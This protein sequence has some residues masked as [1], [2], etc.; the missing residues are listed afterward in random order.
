LIHDICVV[1]W[2]DN[3]T[4]IK[5]KLILMTKIISNIDSLDMANRVKTNLG[6]K[7]PK[8]ILILETVS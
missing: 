8:R 3:I 5:D 1:N 2:I 6:M 7:V 4:R